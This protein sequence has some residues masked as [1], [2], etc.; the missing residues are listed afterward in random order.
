MEK[1]RGGVRS[2]NQ[3][4]ARPGP[5]LLIPTP[6]FFSQ[7]TQHRSLLLVFAW[8]FA[9][10]DSSGDGGVRGRTHSLWPPSPGRRDAACQLPC[11]ALQTWSPSL[12]PCSPATIPSRLR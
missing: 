2:E 8:P 9:V 4:A 3:K 1:A 7:H 6:A 11:P 5:A 10:L 12:S